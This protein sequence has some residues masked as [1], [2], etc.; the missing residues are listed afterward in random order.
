MPI[1]KSAPPKLIASRDLAWTE[2]SD[3]PRFATRYQHLTRAVLGDDYHVGVA[4][5]TERGAQGIDGCPILDLTQRPGGA[6]TD[7]RLGVVGEPAAER[8]NRGMTLDLPQR[9]RRHLAH[10][11]VRV[12]QRAGEPCDGVGRFE[13]SQRPGRGAPRWRADTFTRRGVASAQRA[14]GAG[15]LGAVVLRH[16]AKRWAPVRAEAPV[17]GGEWFP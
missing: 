11:V 8:G 1:E 3:I 9:P 5:A 13:L 7:R 6:E 2:W 4:I 15:A 17:R 10:V 16:V 14:A 12:A